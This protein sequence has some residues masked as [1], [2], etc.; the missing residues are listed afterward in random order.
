MNNEEPSTRKKFSSRQIEFISGLSA[1]FTTTIVTHPLDVIK[2]RLQLQ[3]KS[4][5][6]ATTTSSK[7]FNSIVTII[8]KLNTD[9][10]LISSQS[11]HGRSL[12]PYFISY[13]RG[14]TPN[15]IGNVA[16]WGIYFASYAEFKTLLHSDSSASTASSTGSYFLA[17]SLAGISTCI[18]TNPI[19]VLKTRILGSSRTDA[20]AYRSITDGIYNMIK[21]EGVRSFW[22]GTIPSLFS[23]FQA[24]LQ[25]TIYDNLK[26]VHHN[27]NGNKES[28]STFQYTYISATSKLVSMLVMYPAQVVRSHLQNSHSEDIRI[29]AVVEKL[30]KEEGKVLGFYKGLSANIVRA[31][32]ATCITLV[33]YELVKRVL[34]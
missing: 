34:L 26:N 11:K 32:P 28:L 10:K 31:V 16:A 33:A 27:G 8:K 1:G 2:I 24:S 18:I 15:L 25:F 17:S 9:A 13:Y 7:P 22:K 29:R 30:W 6:T 23:V 3:H 4:Q 21:Y 19:W 14:L 12:T 20:K 5:P